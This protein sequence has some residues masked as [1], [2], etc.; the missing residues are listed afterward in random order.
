MCISRNTPAGV[1]S[2]LTSASLYL[3]VTTLGR[4]HIQSMVFPR[5]G[6]VLS[7]LA[8]CEYVSVTGIS[9]LGRCESSLWVTGKWYFESECAIMFIGVIKSVYAKSKRPGW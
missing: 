4:L 8:S 5:R 9:T 1:V 2:C 6:G 3:W 7:K